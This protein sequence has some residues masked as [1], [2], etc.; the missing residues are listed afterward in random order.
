LDASVPVNADCLPFDAMR[1][2]GMT[3]NAADFWSIAAP[4]VSSLDHSQEVSP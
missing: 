2:A 4:R 1:A 3:T